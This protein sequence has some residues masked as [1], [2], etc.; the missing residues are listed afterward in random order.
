MDDLT[1]A[2]PSLASA[3]ERWRAMNPQE[4]RTEYTMRFRRATIDVVEMAWIVRIMEEEGDDLSD[5]CIPNRDALRKITHGQLSPEAYLRFADRPSLL[6]KVSALTPVEQKKLANGQPVQKATL[7]PSGETDH[8][9]RDPL[10]LKK[11]ELNLVFAEDH[12]R[13]VPEQVAILER[14]R[15][16]PPR[17]PEKSVPNSKA[18]KRLADKL[19]KG[20]RIEDRGLIIEPGATEAT[21]NGSYDAAELYA[22]ADFLSQ[23]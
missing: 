17:N 15:P 14:L 1:L 16:L 7:L 21:L 10:L 5:L 20:G 4:R 9:L 11:E 12:I 19:K 13:T 6:K 2:I 22:I 18:S 3:S 8:R 23:P